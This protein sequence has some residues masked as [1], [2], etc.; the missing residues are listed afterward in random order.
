MLDVSFPSLPHP[1][2]MT[3]LLAVFYA[4]F[5]AYISRPLPHGKPAK[6]LS[7]RRRE[8]TFS[9]HV[10]GVEAFTTQLY[11]RDPADDVELG[12]LGM[13]MMDLAGRP[14]VNSSTYTVDIAT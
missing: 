7:S 3:Y 8:A 1:I 6:K 9:F 11:L 14:P 13:Y 2:A 12:R 10:D 4:A 5:L